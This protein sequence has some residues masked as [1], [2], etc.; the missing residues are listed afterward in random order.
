MEE[1]EELEEELLE[2]K[3]AKTQK[4]LE[5]IRKKKEEDEL[6]GKTKKIEK[7]DLAQIRPAGVQNSKKGGLPEHIAAL[8]KDHPVR[9]RWEKGYRQRADGS[10]AKTAA[11]VHRESS[12]KA[13]IKFLV[14]S[15][16]ILGGSIGAMKGVDSYR[17]ALQK[18]R[19]EVI[20]IITRKG[21]ALDDPEVR[22]M[23]Y[24]VVTTSYLPKLD[25]ILDSLKKA[26]RKLQEPLVAN[27]EAGSYVDYIKRHGLPF[28]ER[29]AMEWQTRSMR[30]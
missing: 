6:L 12:L 18:K 10:W 30:K 21:Y 14:I 2:Q 25:Q 16:L 22:S 15:G 20:D 24:E 26:P 8:P 7:V 9:V 23:Y 29:E 5:E 3:R 19:D 1:I 27:P 11:P 17:D 4:E 28:D 13:W